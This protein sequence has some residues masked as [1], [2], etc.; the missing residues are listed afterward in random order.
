[1][2]ENEKTVVDQTDFPR[3]SVNNGRLEGQT[4]ASGT[5][6]Q[7]RD[8]SLT[9]GSRTLIMG[10][11]NVTPDSFSDGG[12]YSTVDAAVEHAQR[13]AEEGADIIDIGGEST[14]PGAETLTLDEE[15]HRVIPMVEAVR[16]AIDLPISVDTYKAEVAR[17]S[18]EAGAHIIND[19]WGC[20]A[21]PEMA[22]VAALYDCPLIL[23]HNR[24]DKN[25][26][27]FMDDLLDDMKQTIRLA[28]EAGVRDDQIILDPGIGFAK[29][30]EHNLIAMKYLADL[31]K[32]GYPVLLGTSR[33]TFI[34]TTL[35]LPADQVI[36]GTAATVVWGIAQGVD[37]VRV[38]DVKEIKR[39]VKMA[40]AII[41]SSLKREGEK[42]D[43]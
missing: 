25:Y 1:M 18:L 39:T 10:I 16:R 41:R 7:C 13:M 3:G 14:R 36:E 6:L 42:K 20:Q 11:L 30:Y 33:K 32:L 4:V 23:M 5:V 40:D 17:Q 37:I 22:Y 15:L 43:G 9:L 31:N 8:K 2:N 38:H 26:N 29:D 19:V 12:R 24:K 21:D 27:H 34:R 35:G 28:K